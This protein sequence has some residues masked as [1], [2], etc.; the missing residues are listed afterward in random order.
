MKGKLRQI[1]NC[2]LVVSLAVWLTTSVKD[3]ELSVSVT[4]VSEL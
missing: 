1:V 3:T 2:T 4:S